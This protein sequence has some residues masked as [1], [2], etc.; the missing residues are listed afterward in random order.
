MRALPPSPHTDPPKPRERPVNDVAG[1]VSRSHVRLRLEAV[2]SSLTPASQRL[3]DFILQNPEALLQMTITEL[4]QAAGVSDA[5]VTRLCQ[6]VGYLGFSEFRVLLARDVSLTHPH[7]I[8]ELKATDAVENI[9]DKLIAGSIASLSDTRHTV[10]L[11]SLQGAAEMIAKA[12]RVD[13]YG[14]GGS[15]AVALD[16]R[17]KLLRLGIPISAHA[18]VDI[19]MISSSILS[20]QDVVIG[21]SHTGRTEPVVAAAQRAKLGGAGVIALTHNAMSPLAKASDFV[22]SYSAKPT[23]F[24]N[25]SLTG[26]IAQLV[27]GD[28]LYAMIACSQ[29]ERSSHLIDQANDLANKRRIKTVR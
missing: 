6:S 7:V 5:T 20:E 12:R 23:A 27:I 2:Y 26:R 21:V 3:C 9:C 17:H 11:K 14:V 13:V 16:I 29:Y 19:M 8:G 24:S 18:D 25:E 10:D 15:A 1:A 22:L 28:I 4:A